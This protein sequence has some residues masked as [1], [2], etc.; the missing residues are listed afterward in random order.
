[1]GTSKLV[2]QKGAVNINLVVKIIKE[3]LNIRNF[4]KV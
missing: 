4:N 2:D 1:M 3:D